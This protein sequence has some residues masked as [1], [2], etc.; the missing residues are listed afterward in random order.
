MAQ[1]NFLSQQAG[2]GKAL[3]HQVTA[4]VILRE[5]M[6]EKTQT[7]QDAKLHTALEN[8]RCAACTPENIIFLKARI[9]GKHPEQPKLSDK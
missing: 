6:R 2:I 4:V 7:P 3:W 1:Y 8:M 9:T 5:N